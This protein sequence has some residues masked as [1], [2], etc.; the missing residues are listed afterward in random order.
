MS[1]FHQQHIRERN[2]LV[3]GTPTALQALLPHAALSTASDNVQRL[4]RTRSHRVRLYQLCNGSG[5]YVTL[6]PMPPLAIKHC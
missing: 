1:S 5:K 6:L 3:V 2:T 4:L